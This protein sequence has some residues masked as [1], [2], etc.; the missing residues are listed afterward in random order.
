MS[1]SSSKGHAA[2]HPQNIP[3]AG[4]LDIFKR[5]KDEI[6]RDHVSVVAAGVAFFGLLAI[7]PAI[8]ALVSIAGFF[9]DPAEVTNRIDQIVQVLPED[10][11]AIIAEQLRA[12]TGGNQTAVGFAAILGLL[13]ALY[14]AT[15]GTMTLMEGMNIAY[16]EEETR[17]V[18]ELY[19]TGVALTLAMIFGLL[20][21]LGALVV[22]PATFAVMP[23]PGWIETLVTWL[24]WPLLA[25]MGMF[26]LAVIYRYGPARADPEWR[27][28]SPGA[29][30]AMVLW[31]AGTAAF[32]VYVT[33]F[34]SYNETYGTLGGAIILLTWLWLSAFIVLLGA[35]LNAEMEHQTRRDTTTGEELPMGQRGAVKADTPPPGSHG[36]RERSDGSRPHVGRKTEREPFLAAAIGLSALWLLSKVDHDRRGS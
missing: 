20:L 34:G 26:G 21:A 36:G 24:Q 4:W 30:V 12:V 3:R 31:L 16:D 22:V 14:G 23:F 10:A 2:D 6:S 1:N 7:F 35:E 27:W 9:V 5:V 28:V 33:N 25:V 32:S 29:V 8:A 19:G 11:A 13:V 17:G 18:V 15:K